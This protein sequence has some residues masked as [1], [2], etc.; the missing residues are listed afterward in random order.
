MIF[1]GI[2]AMIWFT[3]YLG[4]PKLTYTATVWSIMTT[5]QTLVYGNL[6]YKFNKYISLGAGIT[7]NA[8]IRSVQGPFPYFTSTDRTMA[9]DAIRGGFTNGV[10]AMGEIVPGLRYTAVLGNNLSILG[11]KAANLTRR[12]SKSIS[13]SWMPTTVEFGPRG[14][15]GDFENHE[16]LATRFGASFT[17][18]R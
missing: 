7:P 13:L 8:C 1:T 18:S 17:H 12:F 3:G 15:N 6:I 5:Q 9:E 10:F 16:K 14:G 2:V 4:T 11:V